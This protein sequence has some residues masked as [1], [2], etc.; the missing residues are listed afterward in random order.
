[1]GPL[2]IFITLFIAMLML[3]TGMSCDI[4]ELKRGINRHTTKAILGLTSINFI[5]IPA[6][7]FTLITPFTGYSPLGLAIIALAI[8]PCAPVVPAL[9]N[10]MGDTMEWPVTIFLLFSVASLFVVALITFLLPTH[11]TGEP[12]V[13][14]GL[15][16]YL[17]LV[18]FP[19]FAGIILRKVY[20]HQSL[21]WALKTRPVI[22]IG[23]IAITLVYIACNISLISATPVSELLL[24]VL[25]ALIC[26]AAGVL[27]PTRFGGQPNTL[28]LATAFRNVALAMPFSILVLHDK[29]VTF[30]VVI[31]GTVGAF[32]A[33][34]AVGVQKRRQRA[35]LNSHS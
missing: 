13:Y 8:L 34:T 27:T 4:D 17:L 30:H 21:F 3:Q 33:I 31:C 2:E 15:G 12:S 10:S 28:L 7:T 29:E 6:V 14:L 35:L 20:P 1:M 9:A 11:N 18:Y 25:F 26:I 16:R 24:M 22:G 23:F 19:L 32:M 5:V